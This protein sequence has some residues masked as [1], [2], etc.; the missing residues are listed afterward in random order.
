VVFRGQAIGVFDTWWVIQHLLCTPCHRDFLR[1]QAK[2]ATSGVRFALH[3]GYPSREDATRAFEFARRKGWTCA[4]LAWV[5]GPVS[6]GDAPQ[7][8]V[9]EDGAA[10]L[11]SGCQIGDPWYVV[12]AGINPGVFPTR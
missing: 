9:Q 4:S 8:V 6:G 5:T 2:H 7:P 10:V 1:E 11:L 3:Q 12:Y